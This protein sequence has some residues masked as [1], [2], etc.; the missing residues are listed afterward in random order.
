MLF[1]SRVLTH[2]GQTD[3]VECWIAPE[4]LQRNQR[5]GGWGGVGRWGTKRQ[6]LG[7]GWRGWIFLEYQAELFLYEAILLGWQDLLL[8]PVAR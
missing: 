2:A 3:E 5:R 4:D 6:A 8:F 7:R 1:R